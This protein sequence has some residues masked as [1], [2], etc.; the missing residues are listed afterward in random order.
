MSGAG[1]NK[2]DEGFEVGRVVVLL[3]VLGMPSLMGET[4]RRKLAG[5]PTMDMVRQR[6]RL[7]RSR[8][9]LGV[10]LGDGE[11]VRSGVGAALRSSLPWASEAKKS[12]PWP[13]TTWRVGKSRVWPVAGKSHSWSGGGRPEDS[14]ERRSRSVVLGSGRGVEVIE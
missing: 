4:D 12:S 13:R 8:A 5:G 7:A 1:T 6:R 14:V 11:D 9:G 10:S 2:D 3:V